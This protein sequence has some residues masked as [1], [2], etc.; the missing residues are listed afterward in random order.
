MRGWA[1]AAIA[2]LAACSGGQTGPT[3]SLLPDTGTTSAAAAR[4]GGAEPDNTAT[5]YVVSFPSNEILGFPT[6]AD[7][8]VTPSVKIAGSKTKLSGPSALAVDPASG[9]IYAANGYPDGRILIFPKDANGNVAPKVLAGSNVPLHNPAG[10]AV[11]SN[12]NLYVSDYL[13]KTIYVFAAGA[14]GNAAPIR[15]IAGSN[16]Q[17]SQPSGLSFDSSGHLYV[18]NIRDTVA[19]I[20]EFAAGA[21]GNVAPIATIGGSHTGIGGLY[22]VSLDRNDRIV[23]AYGDRIKIFAAGAHGNVAPVAV[24]KGSATKL[25][26]AT[27]AGTGAGSTIYVTNIIDVQHLKSS[28]LAFASNADGNVAPLRQIAGSHADVFDTW[29]PSIL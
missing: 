18:T 15:T 27:T 23:A 13:A 21:N 28:I 9:K 19:P 7:G 20:E 3:G 8:N 25:V 10:L 11:D 16:T 29:F 24:I 14:A 12:G 17:L 6:N 4:G 2:A 1:I 22:N 5:M 26:D